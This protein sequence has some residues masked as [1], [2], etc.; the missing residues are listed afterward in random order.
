MAKEPVEDWQI[1]H[2]DF[3]EWGKISDK[4]VKRIEITRRATKFVIL[5]KY[6]IGVH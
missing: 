6:Y 2:L 4:P 1:P 3:L 5:K